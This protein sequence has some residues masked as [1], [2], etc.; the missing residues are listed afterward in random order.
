MTEI[1]TREVRA[2]SGY[3]M[4]KRVDKGGRIHATKTHQV[5]SAGMH[6]AKEMEKV[7]RE[8]AADVGASEDQI[9]IETYQHGES[10]LEANPRHRGWQNTIHF[11]GERRK[12]FSGF[13]PKTDR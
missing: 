2:K 5:A 8:V 9:R 11:R 6:S 1:A 13:N 3:I 10:P 4:G 12:V 7:M